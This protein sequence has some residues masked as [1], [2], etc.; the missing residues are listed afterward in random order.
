MKHE[1]IKSA[2][3]STWLKLYFVLLKKSQYYLDPQLKV[4]KR[5]ELLRASCQLFFLN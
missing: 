2:N 4:N 5:R 3:D 1:R